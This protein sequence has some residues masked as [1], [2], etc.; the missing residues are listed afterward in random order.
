[1]KSS[2]LESFKKFNE[3]DLDKIEKL[4]L[5][6]EEKIIGGKP[7]CEEKGS[8]YSG[9]IDARC[10]NTGEILWEQDI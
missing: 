5:S 3:A 7:R 1:M 10:V 2:K 8:M 6:D 4:N 9:C